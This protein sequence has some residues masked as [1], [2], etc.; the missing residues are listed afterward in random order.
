MKIFNLKSNSG[1]SLISLILYVILITIAIGMLSLLTYNFTNNVN[2]VN[3]QTVNEV[4]LDKLNLQL[5]K[6]TKTSNNTI[7]SVTSTTVTF[8]N[9]NIYQYI[10]SDKTVYLKN[11]TSNIDIPVAQSLDNVTFVLETQEN[12]QILTVTVNMGEK[13]RSSEYVIVNQ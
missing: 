4:E 8:S 9:G 2:N 12:K 1:I 11:K 10:A 7:R 6:E 5:V 3:S 13:Q